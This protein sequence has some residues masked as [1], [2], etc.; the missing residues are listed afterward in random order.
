MKRFLVAAGLAVAALSLP[1]TA[2]LADGYEHRRVVKAKPKPK[3]KA[4]KKH[5]AKKHHYLEKVLDHALVCGIGH[6]VVFVKNHVQYSR[7]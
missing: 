4:K 2:A 1:A 6:M 5:H 7:S 3:P